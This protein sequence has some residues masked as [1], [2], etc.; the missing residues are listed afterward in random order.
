MAKLTVYHKSA[1]TGGASNAL[2]GINGNL[3]LDGDRAFTIVAG[4]FRVYYLDADSGLAESSPDVIAPDSNPGDK[5]WIK[6][7]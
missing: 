3:L 2:D 7:T 6:C 1:L 4:V 5:R